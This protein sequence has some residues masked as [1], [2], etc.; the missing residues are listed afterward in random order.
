MDI[1]QIITLLMPLIVFGATELVKVVN[2][3]I[4]G[5]LVVAV[6]VPG[7]S[8]LIAFIGTLIT[9]EATW[10]V[11]FVVGFISVFVNEL[12]RQ[13]RRIGTA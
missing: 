7:L 11:N 9:P 4:S 3:N 6:V 8:A 12:I 10:L 1:T 5:V 2:R 13:L